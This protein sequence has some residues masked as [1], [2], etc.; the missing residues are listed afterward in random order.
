MRTPS[1][2]RAVPRLGSHRL[3]R[4]SPPWS[5][6][7]LDPPASWCRRVRPGPWTSPLPLGPQELLPSTPPHPP[8]LRYPTPET[9][10]PHTHARISMCWGFTA[11]RTEFRFG[12]LRKLWMQRSNDGTS[13]CFLQVSLPRIRLQLSAVQTS[14]RLNVFPPTET[15]PRHPTLCVERRSKLLAN[16]PCICL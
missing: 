7:R 6:L 2:R 5:H 12:A 14:C 9:R 11:V 1:Q 15:H 13:Q 10:T 8:C 4:V 3:I 16:G